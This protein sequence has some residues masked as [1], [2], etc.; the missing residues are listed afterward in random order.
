[1]PDPAPNPETVVDLVRLNALS[2]SVF[3][4]ALTL[5]V[6]DIRIPENTLGTELSARLVELAP[7]GLIYLIGFIVIGGAWGSHQRMLSQI[8]RGDGPLVWLNLLSLLFVTLLPASSALL[9]RFPGEFI[10]IV[11]FAADVILIQLTALW[12]W[13][14]ASKYG[15]LNPSLDPRVVRS[16]GRRLILSAVAFALS[17]ALIVLNAN[18][19]YIGWIGLFVLL[20]ATDWLSWQQVIKTTEVKIPLDGAVR[21]QVDILHGAGRLNILDNV[22][23]NSLV[24]GKFRGDVDSSITREGELLK[25]RFAS[26]SGRGFMSWRYPWAWEMPVLDWNLNVNTQIPLALYIE[27]GMGEID[28]DFTKTH[29]TDFR[30]EAGSSPII[31]RLPANAGQTAVHIQS[32]SPSVVI[33]IPAAVA[34]DIQVFKG[35]GSLDVDLSRFPLVGDGRAYR[36]SDY[37]MAVNRVDIH[38]ELGLGSVRII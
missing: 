11:C 19:V 20:F 33:Y 6:L 17:V 37:D 24:H 16:V 9:G 21:G 35:Q 5:L 31:L 1:M 18:L 22:I 2:D 23:D 38:L 10:A 32:G 12:L 4:F 34:A 7:R 36:S 28:L 30:L 29:L 15:L 14:H 3:A 25:T 13:R 26:H 27:K 8:K